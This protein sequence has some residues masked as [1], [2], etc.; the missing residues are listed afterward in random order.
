MPAEQRRQFRARLSSV[1]LACTILFALP[2]GPGAPPQGL[3]SSSAT[4]FDEPQFS[5]QLGRNRLQIAGATASDEHE[6]A[7]L[8]LASEQFVTTTIT[9]D[10]KMAMA[11][12]PDWETVSTRLLYVVA[13]LESAHAVMDS[14]QI[15]IRGAGDDRPEFERRRNFLQATAGASRTLN[16][17]LIFIDERLSIVE[18]CRRNFASIVTEP[19]RF[20]QSST[21]VRASSYPLLDKIAEFAYDCSASGVAIIGHS[22]ATGT[23]DWNVQLSLTRAEA[24]AAELQQRG[25][26]HNRFVLEGRGGAQPI[27]DNQTVAGREQNRRVEFEL[28]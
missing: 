22:D 1:L 10:F 28:R 9:T 11:L 21:R 12:D 14:S 7:L 15:E 17:D 5:I 16:S 23:A 13:A 26:P 6:A 8:Q 2:V 4:L 25:V 27:A 19:I 3:V 24:V 20:R 18:L